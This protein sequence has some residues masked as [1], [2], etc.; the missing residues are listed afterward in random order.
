MKVTRANTN[1][2]AITRCRF[3]DGIAASAEL[4]LNTG[5]PHEIFR[6]DR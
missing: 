1:C 2:A 4:Q 3:A 5:L 6:D